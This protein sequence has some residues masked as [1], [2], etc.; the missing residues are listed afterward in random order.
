MVTQTNP[1]RGRPRTVGEAILDTIIRGVALGSN[2][3]IRFPTKKS[4]PPAPARGLGSR[5]RILQGARFG[6]NVLPTGRFV[7][8]RRRPVRRI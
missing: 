8:A 5:A 4:R 3:D 2:P 1:P 6:V 7:A